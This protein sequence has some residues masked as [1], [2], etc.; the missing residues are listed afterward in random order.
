MM[1]LVGSLSS[2]IRCIAETPGRVTRYRSVSSPV[3]SRFYRTGRLGATQG[4]IM[5]S[6]RTHDLMPVFYIQCILISIPS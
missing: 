3:C 4:I 5:R 1:N 2:C 6:F